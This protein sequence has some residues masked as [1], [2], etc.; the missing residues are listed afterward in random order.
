MLPAAIP[1]TLVSEIEQRK[2]TEK[3]ITAETNTAIFRSAD[4]AAWIAAP[5]SR[6]IYEGALK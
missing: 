2:A 5:L 3:P 1:A 4:G 6:M